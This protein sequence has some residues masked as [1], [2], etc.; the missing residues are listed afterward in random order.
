MTDQISGQLE[1]GFSLT[2]MYEDNWGG[3]SKMDDFF[4]TFI[5]TRAIKTNKKNSANNGY[6]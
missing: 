4:P 5:D 6:K 2:N 1:A 3:E